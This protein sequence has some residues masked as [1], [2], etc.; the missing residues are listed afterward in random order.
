M[1]ARETQ[2][3]TRTPLCMLAGAWLLLHF[4]RRLRTSLVDETFRLSCVPCTVNARGS[5]ASEDRV[6]SP[7][8][9]NAGQ[10]Q[11]QREGPVG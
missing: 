6:V 4:V 9:G 2:C 1:E 10:T 11:G 3:A 7:C 5:R 8:E